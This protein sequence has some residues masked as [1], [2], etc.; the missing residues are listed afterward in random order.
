[1]CL[2]FELVGSQK[3]V[4][5]LIFGELIWKPGISLFSWFMEELNKR[6]LHKNFA[7]L[8]CAVLL[9]DDGFCFLESTTTTQTRRRGRFYS[10][11]RK[12]FLKLSTL[13]HN[14]SSDLAWGSSIILPENGD[15]IKPCLVFFLKKSTRVLLLSLP[16]RFSKKSFLVPFR[17]KTSR[18]FPTIAKARAQTLDIMTFFLLALKPRKVLWS[19]KSNA[20]SYAITTAQWKTDLLLRW[21]KT[22]ITKGSSYCYFFVFLHKVRW[23]LVDRKIKQQLGNFS[24]NKLKK[25]LWG[26]FYRLRVLYFK[27]GHKNNNIFSHQ[28]TTLGKNPTK[29]DILN[30]CF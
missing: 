6:D 15:R 7:V 17:Q 4:L 26:E 16:K 30:L 21:T 28:R 25:E 24:G 10:R 12:I 11:R 14:S 2:A 13:L 23:R 19:L 9:L 27:V 18:G 5:V 3:Q 22:W 1:M 29:S 20:V 8:W